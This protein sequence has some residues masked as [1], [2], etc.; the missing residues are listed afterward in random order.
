MK[1][2]Y[3]LLLLFAIHSH[4]EKLEIA[5]DKFI[6]KDNDKKISFI[7]NV[8]VSQGA[9]I[10]KAAKI[11]LYFNDD[12]TTK[13]YIAVGNVEFHIKKPKANYQGKCN[14]ME[15]FPKKKKY[16]LS[17]NVKVKDR[18]NKRNITANNIEIN[19]AT[20]AFSITGSKKKAAKL[21][22]DMK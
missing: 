15:Y 4:A 9:T 7:G 2:I 22:F 12:N 1:K 20:G 18:N 11:L 16:I 10:V 21:T 17:G 19:S 8:K 14:S 6:A 5:A 13:K 3:L